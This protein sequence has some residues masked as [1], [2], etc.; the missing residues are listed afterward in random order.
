M[1]L[2]NA[3]LG[4]ILVLC[5]GSAT[6]LGAAVVFSERLVKLASKQV[7]AAALAVSAGVM[8]YVS[9]IEIFVKSQMAFEAPFG[10]SDAYLSA[11]ASLFAGM[12]FMAGVDAL[13]H[14]L[15]PNRDACHSAD[16]C[17]FIASEVDESLAVVV[18][19]P[20]GGPGAPDRSPTA[21]QTDSAS[22][23]DTVDVSIEAGDPLRLINKDKDAP[24]SSQQLERMGLL[25]AL[26]IG[27]HNFPEGLATF[28][29]TLDSPA[30]GGA[31]AVAIAIHNIPEGLCV[32]MPI[33]FST[34]S[35]W[36]AFRWALLSGVSEPIGAGLGWLVLGDTVNEVAYG[37][38]FGM[39][40]GMMVAICLH[41]LI[42]TAHRYDPNDKIVTK[43]IAA[44]MLVMAASLCLFVYG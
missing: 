29:G 35:R 7:L 19:K 28:V 23:T 18:D 14:K 41:E 16:P 30:V 32:A 39:V 1:S 24:D 12:L 34:G 38:V 31:L 13:V 37:I 21:S 6:G 9:F 20:H 17:Q 40:G 2:S 5:A 25:T 33:Y 27:L 15:D 36:K 4:F 26:A 44:G 43:A 11:T 22:P 3:Q 42:P 8:L 10:A